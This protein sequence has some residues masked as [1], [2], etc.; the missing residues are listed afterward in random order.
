[1]N[2]DIGRR[3]AAVAASACLGIVGALAL[4]SP[5]SA[6]HSYVSGDASCPHPETGEWRVTWTITSWAE[7]W[8]NADKFKVIDLSAPIDGITIGE[9]QSMDQAFVG[10][11][12]LTA[13]ITSVELTVTTM[14]NN[15]HASTDTSPTLQRPDHC[16][17][18]PT[19]ESIVAVNCEL[20]VLAVRNIGARTGVTIGLETTKDTAHGTVDNVDELLALPL[21]TEVGLLTVAELPENTDLVDPEE[22]AAGVTVGP[23]DPLAT[24]EAH[25]VGIRLVEGIEVQTGVGVVDGEVG[26]ATVTWE[27]IA[28]A[29]DCPGDEDTVDAVVDDGATDELAATGSPTLWIAGT[30]VAL[31]VIG[32][33]L[34]FLTR[35]RNVDFTA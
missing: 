26:G 35:R 1:V 31:L 15:G 2:L 17:V 29:F 14:W 13:E 16:D 8:H 5:A 22:L 11:Q 21:T 9:W 30:A 32:G 18:E 23:A 27:D 34:Y 33:V 3:I 6:H 20:L 12:V 24:G 7:Q 28:K 4:A 25:A 19:V 10:E